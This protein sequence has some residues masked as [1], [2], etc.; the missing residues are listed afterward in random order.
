MDNYFAN[1]LKIYRNIRRLTQ[2]ELGKK[3]GVSTGIVC[4]MERGQLQPKLGMVLRLVELFDITIE[5]LVMVE[6]K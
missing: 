5:E 4:M 3:L 2:P 1:N 6:K